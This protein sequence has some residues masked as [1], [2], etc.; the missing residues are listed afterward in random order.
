VF[1]SVEEEVVEKGEGF[2]E[3]RTRVAGDREAAE[4]IV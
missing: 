2:D 3:C 1:G 4:G